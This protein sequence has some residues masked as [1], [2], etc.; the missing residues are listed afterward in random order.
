MIKFIC[1]KPNKTITAY[2]RRE[3]IKMIQQGKFNHYKNVVVRLPS[4][5]EVNLESQR[6]KEYFGI[7]R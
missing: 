2:D 5:E 7:K 6:A 4:G 1:W 3:A